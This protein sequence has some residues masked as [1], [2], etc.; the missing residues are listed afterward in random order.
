MI[1]HDLPSIDLSGWVAIIAAFAACVSSLIAYRNSRTARRALAVSSATATLA[2]PQ[3]AAYLIDAFRYRAISSIIYVFCISIENKSTLQNTVVDAELRIPIIRAGIETVSVL[4]HLDQLPDMKELEVKN[5]V[6]LPAPLMAR[7]AFI[8][9]FCFVAPRGMLEDAE[10]ESQTVRIRYADGPWSEVT[11]NI[12]MDI[13]DAKDLE[14]R[15]GT[16]VPV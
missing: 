5:V 4:R 9:N 14:K 7:G 13:V 1:G 10:V 8:G 16:G 12:I 11:S 6:R 2:E 15:R 3:A